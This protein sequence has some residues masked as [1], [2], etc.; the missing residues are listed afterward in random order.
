MKFIRG[1]GKRPFQF[2]IF[3]AILFVVLT[4]VAMFLY[5]GGTG[6]DPDSAGYSFFHNFFSSLGLTIAPNGEPNRASA[7]LFF[8]SDAASYVTGQVLAVDGGLTMQ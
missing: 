6:T 5:A 1:F 8:A 2:T 3:S 7:V 4:I